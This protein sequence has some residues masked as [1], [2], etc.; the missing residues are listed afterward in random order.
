MRHT[1]AP[2]HAHVD[3]TYVACISHVTCMYVTAYANVLLSHARAHAY[4]WAILPND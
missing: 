3:A 4:V 1:D 2:S